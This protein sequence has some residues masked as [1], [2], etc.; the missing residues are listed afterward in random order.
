MILAAAV[1]PKGFPDGCR[2]SVLGN[3]VI[4]EAHDAADGEIIELRQVQV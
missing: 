2:I 3:K 4:F 1:N